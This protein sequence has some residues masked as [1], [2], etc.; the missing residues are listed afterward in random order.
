MP[1]PF[2]LIASA[3]LTALA[4]A[5]T[6][7]SEVRDFTGETALMIECGPDIARCEA[8]AREA[9][10]RGYDVLATG[11]NTT[12]VASGTLSDRRTM[13]SADQLMKVKCK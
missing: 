9:C 10:P 8:R 5:C 4:A 3:A 13:T 6:S 11:E 7:V 2:C 12:I 1:A